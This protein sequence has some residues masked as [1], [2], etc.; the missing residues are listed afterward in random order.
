MNEF[1]ELVTERPD[2]KLWKKGIICPYCKS[3][4]VQTFGTTTTLVGYVGED[5]NH[6]WTRCKCE[7][8]NKEFTF[9]TKG[10]KRVWYTNKRGKTLLGIPRCFEPYVY[11]C[12]H[13]GGDVYRHHYNKSDGK[14]TN[15]LSYKVTDGKSEPQ[16]Y[17]EFECDN[18]HMKVKSENEYYQE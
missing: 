5:M 3:K 4:H 6:T 18:C 2:P 17:T 8:C 9:E 10:K 7:K 1:L 15:C 13:C 16:F 11:T 14:K 12:K